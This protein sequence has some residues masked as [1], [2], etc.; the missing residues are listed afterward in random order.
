MSF[1]LIAEPQLLWLQTERYRVRER[2]GGA[3]IKNL[4]LNKMNF[5]VK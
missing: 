1:A 4:K 3:V 5:I 2:E